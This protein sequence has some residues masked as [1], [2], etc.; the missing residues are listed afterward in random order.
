VGTDE[1]AATLYADPSAPPGATPPDTSERRGSLSAS[2]IRDVIRSKRVDVQ[3]CYAAALTRRRDLR[4]TVT[5]RFLIQPDGTVSTATVV[6]DTVDDA[7]LN[8]CVTASVV[9]WRFPPPDGGG[10]VSVT[11]PF[12]L[13]SH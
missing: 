3:A 7:G 9:T 5:L 11:Y 12:T 6:G 1:S 10:M 2:V 4:G 8:A 13:E